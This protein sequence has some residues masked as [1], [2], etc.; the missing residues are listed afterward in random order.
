MENRRIRNRSLLSFLVL[1]LIGF[2]GNVWAAS[3]SNY[4]SVPANISS[5]SAPMVMLNMSNDHQLFTKAYDD[6]SDLDGDGV[7]DTTYKDDFEYVGYF[8][9]SFCYTYQNNRF[10]PTATADSD[11]H[12]S[13]T[14]DWSGNMLNWATMSR[15]D[16]VRSIL[17]GG[18]R[19]T[20][21]TSLTVLERAFVPED[22]H[23]WAKVLIR[24]SNSDLKQLV[25][26]SVASSNTTISFCNVTLIGSTVSHDST[27]APLLRVA[28]G[29]VHLWDV[30][31]AYQCQW[32]EDHSRASAGQPERF[33]SN[34]TRLHSDMNVRV[35]VCDNSA[36]TGV[37]ASCSPYVDGSNVTTYKPTGLLQ[38]YGEDGSMLFGLITGTYDKNNS[39]GFLRKEIGSI[40]SEIDSDN[41]TFAADGI[42]SSLDA[43]TIVNFQQTGTGY[44]NDA[45]SGACNWNSN[46]SDWTNG[47]CSNWGNPVGE[48]FLEALRYFSGENSGTS[49]YIPSP[50]F[51]GSV[52]DRGLTGGTWGSP[53]TGA[54]E[55]SSANIL[56]FSGGSISYD[57]DDYS[58]ITD[59]NNFTSGRLSTAIN[60]IGNQEGIS[61]N[62]YY[63]GSNG[64]DTPDKLCSAK[65]VSD[66]E[67]VNG[68][69]P[70]AG[71]QEGNYKVSG[72]AYMAKTGD[73]DSTVDG[74][75]SV[76]TYAVSL[77]PPIPTFTIEHDGNTAEIT[78]SAVNYYRS[79]RMPRDTNMSLVKTYI[80]SQ[81]ADSGIIDV[82]FEDLAAGSD[83]DEDLLVRYKYEVTVTDKI[84][85]TTYLLGASG[86][87]FTLS[88]GY[89]INGVT[90]SVSKQVVHHSSGDYSY[91]EAD[92]DALCPGTA[93]SAID[94]SCTVGTETQLDVSYY[95]FGNSSVGYL[96]NPLWYAAKWGGFEDAVGGT[97]D[98]PDSQAEWDSRNNLTGEYDPD[99]VPDNFFLV[100]NPSTLES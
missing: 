50:H 47:Q 74:T 23:A 69:C 54:Q 59:V 65:T 75:Q 29:D 12:C 95:D 81:T 93:G 31:P 76:S 8:D 3:S 37:D 98:V 89:T 58:T 22:A 42:I 16:V 78:P 48:M 60:F 70:D 33:P 97:S 41:G 24:G 52:G 100:S 77:T 53:F 56:A 4:S 87:Y 46:F 63:I 49:A 43:F 92:V 5:T 84:K 90:S 72:L 18:K 80:V 10:E 20:D 9:S 86:T 35:K 7:V 1:S 36:A 99:G 66:L 64:S 68:L 57:N 11:Y 88:A 15:L 62:Q 91:T 2:G 85:V 32:Y 30:Q 94:D 21:T 51:F 19:S 73:L 79:G 44:A 27:A 6:Y 71:G 26:D 25:P 96:E 67:D 61:G 45:S 82:S 14:G 55:C 34:S 17:Y 83:Y 39:G 38:E 28:S 40:G 13:G